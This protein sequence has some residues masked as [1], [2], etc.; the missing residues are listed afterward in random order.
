MITL[1]RTKTLLFSL[2]LGILFLNGCAKKED[3]VPAPTVAPGSITVTNV[4]TT[5]FTVNFGTVTGAT[6]YLVEVVQGATFPATPTSFIQAN[7][8]T[9]ATGVTVSGLT[10][11]FTG[12]AQGTTYVY[13]IYAVNSGG[14]G[15]ASAAATQTTNC[16]LC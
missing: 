4:T 9:A 6:S 14:R 16:G 10:V 7:G 12:L 3:V 2:T 1:F 15:P 11:T 13:R 5:G 8:T